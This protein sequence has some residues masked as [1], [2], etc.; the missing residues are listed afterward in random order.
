MKIRI[1]SDTHNEMVPSA[2]QIEHLD[3][4]LPPL[5][6]D[7]ESVLTLAG[8]V[9]SYAK[10]NSYENFLNHIANRFK[11]VICVGG[12]HEWYDSD[13][14]SAQDRFLDFIANKFNNVYLLNS[15]FP[16]ILIDEVLFAGNTLWTDFHKNDPLAKLEAEK[17]MMDYALIRKDNGKY[18][19]ADDIFSIHVDELQSLIK[20]LTSYQTMSMVVVTHHGPSY[21]SI[22][23][24]YATAGLSNY[25]FTSDLE[26]L[27]HQY[28]PKLW[29]HGH[30][31]ESMDYTVG[32]TRVIANPVGYKR[33]FMLKYENKAF[34]NKLVVE[35]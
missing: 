26:H 33:G 30:T 35:V 24:K 18:I 9:W 22:H 29:I 16:H 31:H 4:I 7:S 32:N 14:P 1:I 20:S 8:D 5:D 11:Y 27:I 34:N 13:Y 3:F 28:S 6:T 2:Y 12:N 15:D 21:Q 23:P 17:Y 19:T 25:A 10:P